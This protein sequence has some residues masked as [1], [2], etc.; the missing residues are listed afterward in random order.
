MNE[1]LLAQSVPD[2]PAYGFTPD[3]S[4]ALSLAIMVALPI[5]VGLITRASTSA[6]LKA[7]LLL[8]VAALKVIIEAWIVAAN[9]GVD[10]DWFTV[11]VT[12]LINFVIAVAVHYG[13]WKPTGVTAAA[14]STGIA[15][16]EPRA[17]A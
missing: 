4:G 2:L 11:V 15:D 17:R 1:I 5:L 9:T 3:L 12:T 6:G 16:R 13:L 10:F 7:V 8:G 14:Q